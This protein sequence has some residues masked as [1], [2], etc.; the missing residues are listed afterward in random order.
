[1]FAQ[2]DLNIKKK[3]TETEHNRTEHSR[4]SNQT[5]MYNVLLD[6]L[7]DVKNIGSC[8]KRPNNPK[9]NRNIT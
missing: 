3:L 2:R 7:R 6:H 5:H 4:K 9:I 8:L 1:M